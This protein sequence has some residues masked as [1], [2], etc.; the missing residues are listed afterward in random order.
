MVVKLY[1]EEFP[2]EGDKSFTKV[3]RIDGEGNGASEKG[4]LPNF[5]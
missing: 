1:C 2:Q 5:L 4:T 3:A